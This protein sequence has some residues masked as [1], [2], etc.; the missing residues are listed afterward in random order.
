[1]HTTVAAVEAKGKRWVNRVQWNSPHNTAV[2]RAG[3]HLWILRQY[4]NSL[5]NAAKLRRPFHSSIPL[6]TRPTLKLVN[7]LSTCQMDKIAT[8][9]TAHGRYKALV[10]RH[11][12]LHSAKG[13][14]MEVVV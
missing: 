6:P 7:F 3:I 2:V 1:M 11:R 13:D 12:N 9:E 8:S 14:R 4:A 10:C 5:Y